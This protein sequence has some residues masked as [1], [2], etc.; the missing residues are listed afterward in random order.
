MSMYTHLLDAAYGQRAPVPGSPTEHS[1][2]SAVRRCR[3]EL[4]RDT[5]FPSDPEAVPAVLA[6]E[7]SYDVALLELAELLGIETDP[8]RFEQP[9][10]ERARLEQVLRNQGIALRSLSDAEDPAPGPS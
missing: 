1:A 2:L 7:I 5:P 6:R 10:Q 9:W 8:S 3:G 4:A